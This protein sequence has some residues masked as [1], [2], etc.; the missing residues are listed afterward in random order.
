MD[1]SKESSKAVLDRNDIAF[2]TVPRV[3]IFKDQRF[4]SYDAPFNRVDLLIHHLNRLLN[5]VVTLNS[6]EDIVRFM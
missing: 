5:P 2:D 4:Y 6:E 3:L 1:I